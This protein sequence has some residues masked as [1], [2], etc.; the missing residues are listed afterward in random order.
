MATM[1]LLHSLLRYGLLIVLVLAIVKAYSGMKNKSGFADADN[2]LGLV[3]LII[4]HVQL[5]LGW[6]LYFMGPVGIKNIQQLGMGEVMK[7]GYARF[8]AV[9]HISMMLLAIVLITIGRVRSKRAAADTDKH[10]LAFR[11]YLIALILLLAGIP[12]PFRAGFE[13]L[14][15]M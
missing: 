7:N 14:G 6:A 11:F 13:G 5:L 4:T 1:Q 9:E 15:W 3:L 12:W 2:K 10:K 8:F